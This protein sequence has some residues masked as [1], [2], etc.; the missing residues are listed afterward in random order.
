[1]LLHFYIL[2]IFQ[3]NFIKEVVLG[4]LLLMNLLKLVMNRMFFRQIISLYFTFFRLIW[5]FLIVLFLLCCPICRLRLLI[6]LCLM[7]FLFYLRLVSRIIYLLPI[8]YIYR[9]FINLFYFF[10]Y[11]YICVCVCVN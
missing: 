1:M 7:L 11:I 10:I 9:F 5:N 4:I 3:A 8:F 2:N 6:F